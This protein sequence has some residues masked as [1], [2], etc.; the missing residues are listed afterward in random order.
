[1]FLQSILVPNQTFQ[2]A[3]LD[4]PSPTCSIITRWTPISSQSTGTPTNLLVRFCWRLLTN[5]ISDP[6]AINILATERP[7]HAPYLTICIQPMQNFPPPPCRTTTRDSGIPTTAINLSKPLS[8]R[9]KTR[10]TTPL[11][12]T[13]PTPLPRLYQLLSSSCYRPDSSMTTAN[14]GGASHLTTRSEHASRNSLQVPANNGRSRRPPRP[15]PYSC[16]PIMNISQ[17]I[18][19][20]KM[21]WSKPSPTLQQPLTVITPWWQISLQ[22][23]VHSPP[24]ALPPTHSSSLPFRTSPSFRLP[25]QTFTSNSALQTSSPLVATTT[26]T[27][28]NEATTTTTILESVP[29]L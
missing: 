24:T 1:M 7:L 8:I 17:P 9:S 19:P 27:V 18:T 22:P 16:Q 11:P 6:F 4:L 13:C 23:I 2:L 26:T 14:C 5:Y 28:G 10:W 25:S 3:L 15:V 20:I 21:K 12:E 29:L